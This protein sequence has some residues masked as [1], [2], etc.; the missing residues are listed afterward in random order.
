MWF[1][2]DPHAFEIRFVDY[3]VLLILVL[4]ALHK[5]GTLDQTQF[6]IDRF[7]IDP[8]VGLLVQLV[9]RDAFA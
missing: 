3:D 6:R 9:E 1:E 5:I 8:V 4:V 7:H 2:L